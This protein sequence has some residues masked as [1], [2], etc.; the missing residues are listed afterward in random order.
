VRTYLDR[1]P[2]ILATLRR[3]AGVGVP[4]AA[5]AVG[6]LG[7]QVYRS[8]AYPVEYQRGDQILTRGFWHNI[9]SGFAFHP[10]FAEREQL[11]IDDVSIMRAV[12]RYLTAQGR[13]DEWVAMGGETRNLAGLRWVPYEAAAREFLFHTCRTEADVCLSTALYYKPG[14]L[15]GLLVWSVGLREIPPD[16]EVFVSPDWGDD[17]KQQMLALSDRLRTERAYAEPWRPEALL[18][19]GLV[20]VALALGQPRNAFASLTGS[21]A[22]IFGSLVTTIIGYPATW[23]IADPA[24]ASEA[25]LYLGTGLGVAWLAR[26]LMRSVR[27]PAPAR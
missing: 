12:G 2:S 11:R 5:L 17:V 20:T 4:L 22:L 8:V 3:H 16:L 24:L 15:L 9:I 21:L 23:T 10:T 18:V 7:L 25:A 13:A 19:W 26:R 27:R 14:S 6:L 1:Q